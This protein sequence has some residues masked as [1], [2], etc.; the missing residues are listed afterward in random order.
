MWSIFFDLVGAL[1]SAIAPLETLDPSCGVDNLLLS[2]EEWMT[3]AAKLDSELLACGS[4][5]ESVPAC[6]G[7]GGVKVFWMYIFLHDETPA[8]SGRRNLP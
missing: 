4:N 1:A 8:Q 7:N 6:A 5:L 2:S 3:R